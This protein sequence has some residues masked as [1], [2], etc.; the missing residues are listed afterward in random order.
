[1]D[2][3]NNRGDGGFPSSYDLVGTMTMTESHDIE[4]DIMREQNRASYE[5]IARA[6]AELDD[7]WDRCTRAMERLR[8][9][10]AYRAVPHRSVT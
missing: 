3:G 4:V 8:E 5:R 7:A 10:R 1:M 9:A 6:Q 2:S